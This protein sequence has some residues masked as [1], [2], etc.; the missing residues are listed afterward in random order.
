MPLDRDILALQQLIREARRI[1]IFT[2]AGISTE[3]GIP[4]FRSPGGIWTRQAPIDFGAFMASEAA[5]REAWRRRFAIDPTLRQAKPNRGHRAVAEL[6]RRG[7][8]AAVITQNID[9]LHQASGLAE[10]QVIELHGNST[11]ARC[12]DCAGRHEIEPLRLAFERNEVAPRCGACG[13]IV[14][15]A[16]VSFGQSMPEEAMRR[17]EAETRAADLFIV[18]GSSLVVYPAAGFPELAKHGG[19][20]LAIVNREPTPL[21][22]LADLVLNG[23]IGQTL[24]AAVSID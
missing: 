16:T 23:A 18:L 21:D 11:Y 8:A 14:K 20:R 22:A 6:V 12:L 15:T 17:A 5:R 2:G 10:E 4:D 19:A 9:G 3:S 13:G 7:R 1:A 24:G